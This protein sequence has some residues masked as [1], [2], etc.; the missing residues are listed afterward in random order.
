M[1]R[2]LIGLVV[3]AWMWPMASYAAVNH[4]GQVH[5]CQQNPADSTASYP[6]SD[7][8]VK[9][10]KLAKPAGKSIKAAGQLIYITGRLVDRN[11]VPLKDAKVEIWHTNPSGSYV[12]PDKGSF[13]NPYPLFAGSGTA[14]ADGEGSYGFMSTFPGPYTIYYNR[15]KRIRAPHINMRI[16]HPSLSKPFNVEM[17]FSGD[18][19]NEE[20]PYFA[21]YSDGGKALIQAST[22]L[23]DVTDPNKGVQ[24]HY[25]IT[26][27][28]SDPFRGF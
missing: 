9:S 20:D 19:R 7:K 12:H 11:C 16:T 17:Y 18:M 23:R 4:G 24:V 22:K 8:I 3:A 1:N 13:V 15:Q 5:H 10:N 26:V 28:T 21:R 25:D 2:G 27:P 14:Y 6:G